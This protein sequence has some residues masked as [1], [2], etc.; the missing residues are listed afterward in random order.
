MQFLPPALPASLI[1][2]LHSRLTRAPGLLR[3]AYLVQV[4]YENGAQGHMI[5][6]IGAAPKSQL[7]LSRAMHEAVIFAG[8]DGLPLDV[9]FPN[10]DDP[11]IARLMRHAMTLD[12]PEPQESCRVSS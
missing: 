9:T 7:A 12:L 8:Q 4:V 10:E 2:A 3:K 5:A 1:E 11:L 6:L